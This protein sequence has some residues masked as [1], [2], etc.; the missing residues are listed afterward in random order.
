LR[1]AGASEAAK[2]ILIAKEKDPFTES[3]MSL[4]EKL[5]HRGKGL[6]I[7][8]GYEPEW[9]VWWVSVLLVL[10]SV[11]FRWAGRKRLFAPADYVNQSCVKSDFQGVHKS[12]PPFHPFI[13]CVEVLVPLVN[14]QQMKHWLPNGNANIQLSIPFVF[15]KNRRLKKTSIDICSVNGAKLWMVIWAFQGIGWL[16]TTMIVASVTRLIKG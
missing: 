7:G 2:E 3:Q 15:L 9:A 16:M 4:G 8:Y 13:Y 6:F 12:Y 14:F 10:G 1:S 11:F 5:W